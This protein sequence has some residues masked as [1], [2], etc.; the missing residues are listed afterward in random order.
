M[1]GCLDESKDC[2][3]NF[4]LSFDDSQ[5]NMLCM[6]III[7]CC[8]MTCFYYDC[9]VMCPWTFVFVV[10]GCLIT[11]SDSSCC[12][13]FLLLLVVVVVFYCCYCSSVRCAMLLSIVSYIILLGME[14]GEYL[15]V[16]RPLLKFYHL[17]FLK[18]RCYI[19][20]MCIMSPFEYVL[21]GY[22]N[23]DLY[24]NMYSCF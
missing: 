21:R 13:S 20:A 7:C 9:I 14:T 11:F 5:W 8:S 12:F 15:Q 4:Y 2:R 23:M 16:F 1:V 10:A 6:A 24:W 17:H 3:G 19:Y 18:S 22:W